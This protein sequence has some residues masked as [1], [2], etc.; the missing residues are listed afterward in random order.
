MSKKISILISACLLGEPVRYN[1]TDLS[2]K[3]HTLIKQWCDSQQLVSICPEVAGGMT[4]PR[5][6]AEISEGDGYSVLNFQ[7]KVTDKNLC[8]VSESFILGAKKALS[9]AQK[10][11]CI[12]AILTERSP[13][14][15]SQLIYDGSFSNTRKSGLGVT[16]ALLEQNNIKVFNQYQ[17]EQLEEYLR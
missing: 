16:T 1:G 5:N 13:S 7:A 8:D 6:P 4:I 15:G 12:A 11:H 9:L 17:L 10:H 14:C 3:H 2:L